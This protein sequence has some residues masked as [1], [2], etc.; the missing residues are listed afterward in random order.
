MCILTT[1]LLCVCSYGSV[2]VMLDGPL[3]ECV[4]VVLVLIGGPLTECVVI[5]LCA[6]SY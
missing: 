4:V 2:V 1:V 5:W 6:C 3:T